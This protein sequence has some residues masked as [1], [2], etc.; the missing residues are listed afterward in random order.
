MHLISSL[1][2]HFSFYLSNEL[3]LFQG[4]TQIGLVGVEDATEVTL[5]FPKANMD[6]QGISLYAFDGIIADVFL[7]RCMTQKVSSHLQPDAIKRVH[8]WPFTLHLK[9]QV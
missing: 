3:L 6:I 1:L 7:D 9:S 5:K 8:F 4:P 2:M